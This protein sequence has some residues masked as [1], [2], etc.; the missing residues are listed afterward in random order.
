MNKV[1]IKSYGDNVNTNF[2]GKKV[3]KENASYKCLSL[4]MLDSVIRV[5]KKY[6]LQTL[7]KDSKY[8]TKKNKIENLIN[9]DFYSSS[10][11]E[12]GNDSGSEPD[13]EPGNESDNNESND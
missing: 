12:S 8:E 3:P 9:D 2:Q 7:L 5:N 13:G 6:Y 1:K 11:D 4:V 10:L